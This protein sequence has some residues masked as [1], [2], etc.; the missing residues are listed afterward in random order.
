MTRPVLRV[1]VLLSISLGGSF[2]VVGEQPAGMIISKEKFAP[3]SYF[4]VKGIRRYSTE[5]EYKRAITDKRFEL[6]KITYVSD[7]QPVV[8]YLYGAA[9]TD[10]VKRP[11]IVFNRG[12]YVVDG[13]IALY[14]SS[15]WRLANDGFLVFAPMYRGSDGAPGHDEMGGADLDDLLNGFRVLNNV[16]NADT[17]N[18]FLYGESR[19]GMMV[20]AALREGARVKAAAT[21]GAITDLSLYFEEQPKVE[22]QMANIVWP[23]YKQDREAILEHRSAL[24]WSDRI[25][26][27]VLIMHGGKDEGVS[28]MHSLRLAESLQ[29]K[30]KDYSLIIFA[31]DNHVLTSHREER[32]AEV[33]KWFRSHLA[34]PT[35]LR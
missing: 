8:A 7:G 29:Q 34:E 20:L 13:E 33:V 31:G 24:R 27:P 28:P 5:E 35:G 11:V 4:E 3:P 12:S 1:L 26:T 32:D 30:K 25:N 15:F 14:L 16:R 18:V 2:S 10:A 21:V 17:S 22:T 19:G 23:N 6:S 9:G